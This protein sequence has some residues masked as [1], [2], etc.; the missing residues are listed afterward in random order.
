MEENSYSKKIYFIMFFFAVVVCAFLLKALSSVFLPIVFSLLLSFVLFPVINKI[1][2]FTKIPWIT[3]CLLTVIFMVVIFIGLSSLIVSSLTK[4]ISEY[5][6][7][8]SKFMSIYQ[9]VA[10]RFNLEFDSSKSFI[11]NVWKYFKVREYVQSIAIFLS[12]GVFSFGKNT[13]LILLL[14][15]FLLIEMRTINRKINY[16]FIG[17][18]KG[19][20]LRITRRIVTETVRFISIKF[21]IS[22]MTGILVYIGC[23]ILGIDFPIVWG[24]LSF[25][26]NFIP[27]FGSIISCGITT[28]FT[29]LQYYPNPTRIIIILVYM[30]SVNFVLGN[31]LEPRIEGK[32][33]GL[34]PFVILISL[35]LWG[36]IWGFVGMLFAVPMTVIIKIFCENISYLH[37]FAI[38]LGN[39]P[40]QTRKDFDKD[41]N[42]TSSASN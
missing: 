21:Y 17:K 10:D 26:M 25:L 41:L 42:E 28:L 15:T 32:H 33:L 3:L 40:K 18:T 31:V 22:L 4:I 35:S 19:K 36:Y 30:V 2:K 9:L 6:K 1:N 8:E 14:L 38:L 34:S 16:A 27:T 7:Y 23:L 12:T 39:D 29:V 5:P 13:F 11:D 24:F 20:V 37:P